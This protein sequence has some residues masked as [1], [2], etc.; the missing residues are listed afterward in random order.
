MAG[1][2]ICTKESTCQCR[3]RKRHRFNP[4]I[5]KIH[6]S[7]KWHPSPVF[8]PRESQGQR[9]LVSYS[10][11]ATKSWTRLND[12][13][14]TQLAKLFIKKILNLLAS[15][16]LQIFLFP[17]T[18]ESVSS[19]V[20]SDSLWHYGLY[21][22]GSSVHGILQVRTVEW[23]AVPFSRGSSRPVDWTWVS[24]ISGRFFTIWVTRNAT[25]MWKKKVLYA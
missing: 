17:L 21:P 6:W 3:R 23:V 16:Q 13:T 25:N 14:H 1:L 24:F 12:W 19:S 15:C 9:S 4:W 7:S 2:L 20:A 18:C 8:L 5:G 11:W 22:P 10:P